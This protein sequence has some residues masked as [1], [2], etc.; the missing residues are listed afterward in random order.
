MTEQEIENRILDLQAWK[1]LDTP[2]AGHSGYFNA[3]P[4]EEAE[5][6]DGGMEEE[7]GVPNHQGSE[8]CKIL[9][10]SPEVK[11]KVEEEMESWLLDQQDLEEKQI[12][13]AYSGFPD[14]TVKTEE[15]ELEDSPSP[16]EGPQKSGLVSDS[17]PDFPAVTVK[18]EE[19]EEPWMPDHQGYEQGEDLQGPEMVQH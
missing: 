7:P 14:A 17:C 1:N 8:E 4:K 9:S 18:A 5:E 3:K 15:Q 19:E 16:H 2:P 12:S 10:G 6:E 11:V 13:A